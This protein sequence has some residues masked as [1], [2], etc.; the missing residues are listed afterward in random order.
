VAGPSDIAVV[1]ELDNEVFPA[2]DRDRQPAAPGE[3][4]AGVLAGD[5]HVLERLGEVVAYLHTDRS[6]PNMIFVSGIAVRPDVQGLGLG[7]MMIDHFLDSL[8]ARIRA[9]VPITTITSPRNLAMLRLLFARGFAGRWFLK[10]YFGPGRD[11]V[12]CQLRGQET[13]WPPAAG[14]Q[15]P[16][17]ALDLLM[18]LL[19]EHSHVIRALVHTVTGPM[20]ELVPGH[21]EQF[22]ASGPP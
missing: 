17:P 10:D 22:P 7:T 12:G 18:R 8:P 21:G 4:E 2:G 5:V 1:R 13:P 3:L 16:A 20:F 19:T 15:V 9:G 14:I 6:R 11:R